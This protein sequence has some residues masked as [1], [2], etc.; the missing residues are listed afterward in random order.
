MIQKTKTSKLIQ[1]FKNKYVIVLLVLGIIIFGVTNYNVF[2][3]M[4]LNRQVKELQK[5]EQAIRESIATD[6][7][8]SKYL[9]NDIDAIEKY[10]REN[11]F[12]KRENEDV[13]V[14]SEDDVELVDD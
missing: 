6:S 4:K 3:I 8:Q 1:F 11:Y 5:E 9:Q 2:F 13:Y 7:I 10:G 12:M 14:V